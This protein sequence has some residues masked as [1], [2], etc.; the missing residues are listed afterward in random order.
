M[1]QAYRSISVLKQKESNDS[2]ERLTGHRLLNEST[3]SVVERLDIEIS[4]HLVDDALDPPFH[5]ALAVDNS[6]APVPPFEN[7]KDELDRVHFR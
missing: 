3:N 2:I 7:A 6:T 1:R 4:V 5:L